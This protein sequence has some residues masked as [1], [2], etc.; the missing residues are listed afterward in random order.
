MSAKTLCFRTVS[1]PRSFVRSSGQSLLPQYLTNGLSSLDEKGYSLAPTND[2]IIVRRSKATGGEGIPVDARVSKSIFWFYLF[3]R[4]GN[5]T[6]NPQ[7]Y[8]C[9]SGLCVDLLKML[10]EK[11]SFDFEL[12]EVPDRK[13]GA[14][15]R[16]SSTAVADRWGSTTQSYYFITRVFWT[17][18]RQFTLSSYVIMLVLHWLCKVHLQRSAWQCHL[19]EYILI[20]IIMD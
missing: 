6:S 16:V 5:A 7:L 1:P 11:I 12:F 8:Q 15:D 17:T 14:Y 9:C 3:F 18:S 20:I 10:G 4:L 2:L 13:W 19:N